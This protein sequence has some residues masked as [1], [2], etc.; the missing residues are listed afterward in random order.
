MSVWRNPTAAPNIPARKAPRSLQPQPI[1][2]P[3]PPIKAR[4]GAQA[5]AHSLGNQSSPPTSPVG[6]FTN[7]K[8]PENADVQLKNRAICLIIRD[9]R[10]PQL[11]LAHKDS[12]SLSSVVAADSPEVISHRIIPPVQRLRAHKE[13]ILSDKPLLGSSAAKIVHPQSDHLRISTMPLDFYPPGWAAS[14]R[15]QTD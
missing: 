6:D 2:A 7:S 13:L 11:F 1:K 3:K 9:V 14:I 15:H 10:C 8:K 4:K 12:F 5:P